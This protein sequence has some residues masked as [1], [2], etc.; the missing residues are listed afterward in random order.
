MPTILKSEIAD[1]LAAAIRDA[2]TFTSDAMVKSYNQL[3]ESVDP[4][5]AQVYPSPTWTQDPSGNTDRTTFG[6]GVRQ[7]LIG[8]HIDVYARRRSHI[9]EDM[10]AV[11]NISDEI[12]AIF[13]EQNTKPYFNE[14]GIKAF[15]WTA[16][17]VTFQYADPL[18]L[19]AGIRYVVNV[20]VF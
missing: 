4:P 6:G 11:V 10:E 12:E 1:A 7:T 9:A 13:E 14:E 8:F 5:M 16:T 20:Q 17:R 3:T 2:A 18:D 15:N 19:Y